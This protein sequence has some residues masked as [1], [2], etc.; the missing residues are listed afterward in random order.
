RDLRTAHPD[1]RRALGP[2]RLPG[3]P[4]RDER[5][6]GRPLPQEARRERARDAVTHEGFATTSRKGWIRRLLYWMKPHKRDAIVAFSVAIVGTAIMAFAP[7]V[8]KIIV[9]DVV[10]DPKRALWPWL[11]LLVFFGVARFALAYVRRY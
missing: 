8:E 10:S 2:G 1:H 5:R 7:L 3:E 6:H 4:R 11:L 9:D